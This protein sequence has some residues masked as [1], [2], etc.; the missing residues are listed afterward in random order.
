MV[1]ISNMPEPDHAFHACACEAY[2]L[3]QSS[4]QTGKHTSAAGCEDNMHS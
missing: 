2:R 4:T 1:R 3:K